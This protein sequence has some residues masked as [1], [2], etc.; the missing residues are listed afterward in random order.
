MKFSYMLMDT[1]LGY[2]GFAG[3]SLGLRR[4]V[5]PQSS[6]EMVLMSLGIP[7]ERIDDISVFGDLPRRLGQYLEGQI[8]LFPDKLDF[9]GATPFQ[10]T[11]WE[12][13]RD[14]PYGESRSYTWV[15]ERVGNPQAARAVGQALSIN[16]MPLVVPCHRVIASGG[17]LGGYRGGLRMNEW[18]L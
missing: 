15:A 13:T 6:R 3:S 7:D 11:V 17:R 16:H 10:R 4:V 18:L 8:V 1:S 12:I 5:L 2:M 14:I 9:T